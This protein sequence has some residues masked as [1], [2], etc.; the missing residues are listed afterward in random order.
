[1]FQSDSSCGVGESAGGSWRWSLSGS[2]G[3]LPALFWRHSAL[4]VFLRELLPLHE[5]SAL[6]HR[7]VHRFASPAFTLKNILVLVWCCFTFIWLRLLMFLRDVL[8][9]DAGHQSS[10]LLPRLA[11]EILCPF[12]RIPQGRPAAHLTCLSDQSL[13]CLQRDPEH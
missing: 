4:C 5:L 7:W 10:L 1:M 12:P 11:K 13:L 8:L 9:H 3:G 2:N 6:Q